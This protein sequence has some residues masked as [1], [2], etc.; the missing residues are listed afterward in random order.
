MARPYQR[1]KTPGTRRSPTKDSNPDRIHGNPPSTLSSRTADNSPTATSSTP[2]SLQVNQTPSRRFRPEEIYP[3]HFTLADIEAPNGDTV[4]LAC[5]GSTE[6]CPHCG[7]HEAHT[8][9]IVIAVDGACR[10][11]GQHGA[12]A[13]VGVYHG[14]GNEWNESFVLPSEA[15]QTNQVAELVACH[16]ALLDAQIKH[17]CGEES[18]DEDEKINT[19]VIKSDSEY[20]VRGVTEWT[21]KW[22]TN[23]WLNVR[24]QPVANGEYFRNIGRIVEALE[25][26]QVVVWFWLVPRELNEDADQLAKLALGQD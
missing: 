11:N 10:G 24:G 9:S 25:A 4:L 15:T 13:S 23:G 20:V 19:V 6:K 2:Y 5:P 12:Q 22:K 1:K 8:G 26:K 7:R 17:A 18:G 3:E 16:R 21:E 14:Y